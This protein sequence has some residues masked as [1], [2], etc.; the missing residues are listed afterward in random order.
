MYLSS[1]RR[2]TIEELAQRLETSPRSIYRYLD[3]FKSSGFSVQKKDDCYFLSRESKNFKEL[4][5]LIH[6]TEEE[7]YVFNGLLDCLYDNNVMKQNLRRKLASV[8]NS[9]HLA[10]FVVK[11]D[12][13]PVV[14]SIVEA[15]EAKRKVYLRDYYSSHKGDVSDRLVEPFGFTTNYEQIWCYDLSDNKNKVFKTIRVSKVD[16]L[17]ETWTQEKSHKEGYIDIFRLT[18]YKLYP[19]KLELNVMSY[20]LLV[21]EYPLAQRDIIKLD[22]NSWIL[23]TSVCSYVGVCRFVVG[24][25]DNIKIVDSPELVQYVKD[26]VKKN[27]LR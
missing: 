27:V 9:T 14:H 19:V 20:N 12:T 24:L 11:K 5:Q 8:Y 1:E 22:K 2:Y 6:F 16:V 4:S 15:I 23:D 7:A 13:A 21:E 17:D 18:G 26:F 10:D 3:T 25:A